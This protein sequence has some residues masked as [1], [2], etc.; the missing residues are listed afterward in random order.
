MH[1][2]NKATS[3][4]INIVSILMSYFECVWGQLHIPI[5]K[6][7]WKNWETIII[8]IFKF[9]WVHKT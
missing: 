3:Q 5:W 7:K 6:L 1:N 4:G 8:L 9:V 2:G